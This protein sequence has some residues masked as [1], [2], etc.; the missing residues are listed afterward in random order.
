LEYLHHLYKD[1]PILGSLIDPLSNI[2]DGDLF[3]IEWEALSPLLRTALNREVEHETT[4]I[5]FSAQGLCKTS[6]I[7]SF[8]YN[9]ILTNVPFRQSEDL[10]SEFVAFAKKEYPLSK[11][12][13]ATVFHQRLLNLL[14]DNGSL[15]L[16]MPQGFLYKDYYSKYRKKVFAEKSF[17]LI[18]RLGARAFRE[19]TGEEVKVTLSIVNNSAPTNTSILSQL[20]FSSASLEEKIV[21]LKQGILEST[22]QAKS[23]M[24]TKNIVQF[25]TAINRSPLLEEFATFSN[26]IQTGDY[27]RFGR[28]FWEIF[29]LNEDWGLQLS[30]VKET[31]PFGG[32]QRCLFLGKGDLFRFVEEKVGEGKAG[33][34]LRGLSLHDKKGIAISAMGTLKA[35]LFTGEIFD[36]NTI[37][38]IPKIESHLSAIW[39]FCSSNNYN[40]S[41]RKIDQSNK[42][43]GALLRVPFNVGDAFGVRE[44]P[45]RESSDPTQWLFGGIAS[46]S[47]H[48]LHTLI[49]RLLGF[50]WP[51]ES[52]P[53]KVGIVISDANQDQLN[54]LDS[55]IDTDGIVP[56]DSLKG[57]PG[58]VDRVRNMLQVYF[59]GS[60]I[61]NDE[62]ELLNAMNAKS[63]NLEAWL[64]DEFFEQHCKLFKHHPFIWHIWDGRRDGFHA[65]VNYHK[66]AAPEGQGR[67]TLESVIYGYLGD[68][69]TRQQQAVKGGEDGAEARLIAAQNLK[70]RLEQILQGN[71]PFDLFIRWKP[72]KQQPIGWDPDIKDGVSLNVRPFMAEDLENGRSGAGVLRWKPNINCDADKGREPARTKEEFPWFWDGEAFTGVRVNDRHPTLEERRGAR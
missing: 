18:I 37:V 28:Y 30:T 33:S 14:P 67:R 19:I 25:G 23:L 41:V 31:I 6:E 52:F 38:I 22:P 20:D 32:R 55:H 10:S 3:N 51:A 36:D 42:V 71:P 1:A 47:S 61:S 5:C 64:R 13:I 49:P 66:L 58:I 46:R 63:E 15:A 17:P 56:F 70:K 40:T 48:V 26:G 8:K 11:A 59:G 43:R 2:R 62:V 39:E 9:L 53:K 57:E 24:S 7:L 72:L 44:I 65:L 34:W 29:L 54:R 27:P 16:V 50:R 69:I 35:T 60:W 68:W 4:E 12:D 21:G 45:P